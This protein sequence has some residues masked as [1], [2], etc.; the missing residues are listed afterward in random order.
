MRATF[1]PIFFIALFMALSPPRLA[2]ATALEGRINVN[3]ANQPQLELLPFTG[4]VRA[5]AILE[6]RKKHGPFEN[7]RQLL[8][9]PGIGP[10][11]YDAIKRYIQVDGNTDLRATNAPSPTYQTLP[12]TIFRKISTHPGEL[13]ILPD[14]RF[15]EMLSAYIDDARESIRLATFVFK[16]TDSPNNRAR[17]LVERLGKARDRGVAVSVVLEQS[18][19]SD[20][21]NEENRRTARLLREHGIT[22]IEDSAEIT[23]HMKLAVI[24][25]R[26]CFVGSHNLTHSALEYNHE[27]SLLIDSR[28]LA[29][30]LTSYITEIVN[31]KE[32]A[33]AG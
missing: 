3:T 29:E 32:Q 20:S 12:T 14:S 11:T 23:S 33:D 30:E 28:A 26:F 13:M 19:Y 10:V 27:L 6:Y 4:Q 21:I 24:D 7:P 16:V 2:A 5:R 18:D 1:L 15:Y 17:Q 25:D 22:V 31:E 8:K 9:V